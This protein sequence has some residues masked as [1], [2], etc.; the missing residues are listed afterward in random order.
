ME[1]KTRQTQPRK[2][3]KRKQKNL[4]KLV[5]V[6]LIFVIAVIGIIFLG[7]YLNKRMAQNEFLKTI[8]E[9]VS[10][11]SKERTYYDLLLKTMNEHEELV[12]GAEHVYFNLFDLPG[13]E[14]AEKEN[15]A[16]KVLHSFAIHKDKELLIDTFDGL[17][18]RNILNQETSELIDGIYVT[19]ADLDMSSTSREKQ[20]AIS[21]YKTSDL[22]PTITYDVILGEEN[23]IVSYTL[24]SDLMPHENV[25]KNETTE[26]EVNELEEVNESVEE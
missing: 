22:N 25:E 17:Y 14:H 10:L 7:K 4:P 20:F 11:N 18:F 24:V 15:I 23:E 12:T 19:F 1:E 26:E 13:L 3:Q 6:I 5:F 16:K 21:I 8:H 2:K 9:D